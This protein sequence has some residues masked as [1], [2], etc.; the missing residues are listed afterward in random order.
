MKREKK[1]VSRYTYDFNAARQRP[2][3][4]PGGLPHS[5]SGFEPDPFSPVGSWLQSARF[6]D[7]VRRRVG[8]GAMVVILIIFALF[9]V[10]SVVR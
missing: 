9:Y 7:G 10:L 1:Q 6:V 3:E 2:A 5:G 4:P 8:R